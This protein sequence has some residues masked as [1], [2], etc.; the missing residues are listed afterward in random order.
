MGVASRKMAIRLRED[1]IFLDCK[2]EAWKRLLEATAEQM[3]GTD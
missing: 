2:K 3:S 1:G